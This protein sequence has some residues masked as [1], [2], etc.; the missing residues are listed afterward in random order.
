MCVCS[1]GMQ[2]E[3][4]SSARGQQDQTM[5]PQPGVRSVS[6]SLRSGHTVPACTACAHGS[7]HDTIEGLRWSGVP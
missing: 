4:E 7:I 6:A 1:Q 5:G 3:E 2:A